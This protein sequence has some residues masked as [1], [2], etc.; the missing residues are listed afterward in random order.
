MVWQKLL[1]CIGFCLLTR[2]KQLHLSQD[3]LALEAF[4]NKIHL[5]RIESGRVNL[6]LRILNKLV[7]ILHT[8]VFE[9]CRQ[10]ERNNLV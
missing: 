5:C 3:R 6:S 8:T 9:F 1:G 4:V 2:R 10:M 7:K